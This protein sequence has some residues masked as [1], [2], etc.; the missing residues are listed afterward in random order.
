MR[1]SFIVVLLLCTGSSICALESLPAAETA[2][3]E[4]GVHSVISC[5]GCHWEEPDRIPR[6]SIPV[7][8][9]DCHPGP[10]EDFETSV[11]WDGGKAH[12]ICTDCHGLHGILPIANTESKAHRSQVCAD[13]HSGPADELH[14]GPHGAAF[15]KTDASY[16]SSCHSN[17]AVQP[18]TIA[19]IKPACEQCHDPG[20]EAL[21]LGES[22]SSRFVAFTTRALATADEVK[23]ASDSGYD[24]AGID[25]T[26]AS[27][28]R[29]FKQ[30]RMI[31]H[32]L[33]DK[34]IEEQVATASSGLDRVIARVQERIATQESREAGVVVV[35]VVIILAFIGLHLK[36]KSLENES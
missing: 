13:C 17:H 5:E 21:A 8:C 34:H 24:V 19:T 16:C 35:W 33:D 6:A 2:A 26:F 3:F 32:S 4:A 25:Q 10:H 27:A 23:L 28:E 7:V 30:A 29:Q 18:P 15:D 9:G 22:V 1:A 36:R 31:W 11:H 14:Q 12:A 20:S